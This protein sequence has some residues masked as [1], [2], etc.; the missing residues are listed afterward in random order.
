MRETKTTYFILCGS[1][2]KQNYLGYINCILRHIIHPSTIS[3]T[4][5]EVDIN[6]NNKKKN[7]E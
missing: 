3:S 7:T 4:P 6:G 5:T 2:K 1:K